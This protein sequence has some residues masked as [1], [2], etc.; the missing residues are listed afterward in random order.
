[1][2]N[3]ITIYELLGLVKDRQ[4]QAPKKIKYR[5]MVYYINY[6]EGDY[7][8]EIKL[9]RYSDYEESYYLFG[10]ID[11]FK[12]LNDEVEILDNEDEEKKIPEKIDGF[13][14]RKETEDLTNEEIEVEN[15]LVDIGDKINKIIDYLK[16]KGE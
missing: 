13:K 16:S 6:D 9:Y 2:N 12:Y 8:S 11:I 15:Y 3:K 10:E 5:N 1:M 4:A 14:F 7:E